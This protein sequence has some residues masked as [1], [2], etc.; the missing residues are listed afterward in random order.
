MVFVNTPGGVKRKFSETEKKL[1]G[2][3][4]ISNHN[5]YIRVT[6]QIRVSLY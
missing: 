4:L 6:L 3:I 5:V 2:F 1:E